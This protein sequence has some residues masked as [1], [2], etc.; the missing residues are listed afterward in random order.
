MNDF[1]RSLQQVQARIICRHAF[2]RRPGAPGQGL[3]S[4]N[5]CICGITSGDRTSGDTRK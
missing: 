4:R 3:L 1:N 5:H 2:A